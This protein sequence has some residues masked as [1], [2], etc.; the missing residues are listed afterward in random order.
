M[1]RFKSET[2]K[3]CHAVIKLLF[4]EW[5]R[6]RDDRDFISDAQPFGLQHSGQANADMASATARC[7]SQPISAFNSR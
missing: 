7:A 2:L 4:R 1:D 3:L 6:R 5:A